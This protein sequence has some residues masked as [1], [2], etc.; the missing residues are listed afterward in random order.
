MAGVIMGIM[1]RRT[2]LLQALA[3]TP[4]DIRRLIRPLDD[5][6]SDW[7]ASVD[8]WSPMDVVNHLIDVEHACVARLQRVLAEHEPALP[9]IHPD[10]PPRKTGLSLSQAGDTFLQAREVTL[11][12]L[13]RLTPGQ[14]QRAAIHE[15]KGRTT[16]R[17]LI[18]DLVDHDIEHT[19]QLVEI[20]QSRRA[21]I[22]R[23][24]AGSASLPS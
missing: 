18:Q 19:N 9:C 2:V 15:T 17:F 3:S 8:A 12:M 6:A 13:R 23:V 1:T 11:E 21:A 20:T 10:V 24:R 22:K 16:L 14:W 4:A 5:E 7:K